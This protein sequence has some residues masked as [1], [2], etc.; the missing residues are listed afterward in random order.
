MKMLTI[1]VDGWPD[2]VVK[3]IEHLVQ[4]LS[5]QLRNKPQN[6]RTPELPLWPGVSLPPEKLRRVE[7]Y[8]DAR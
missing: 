1:N 6:Q 2:R 5:H 7:I 8:R 4:T 3:M